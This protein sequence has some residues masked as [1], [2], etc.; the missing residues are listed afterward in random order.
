MMNCM[1]SSNADSMMIV[2]SI[3]WLQRD[4]DAKF[5]CLRN[6]EMKVISII[7]LLTQTLMLK[8]EK[9]KDYLWKEVILKLI[10]HLWNISE[11]KI[12]SQDVF[13][14]KNVQK[15]KTFI[16]LLNKQLQM[17]ENMHFTFKTSSWINVAREEA[18]MK[19]QQFRDDLSLLCKKRKILM[20]IMKRKEVKEIQ[21]RL[22]DQIFQEIASV[23]MT[24]RD[25][26]MSL[27]KLESENIA[28]H[29]MSLKAQAALKKSQTWV[30][31]IAS[32]AHVMHWS[33]A[34][35]THDVHIT[36]NTSNQKMIIKK[37]MKDNAR[38][39]KNLKML[40]IA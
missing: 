6:D 5:K 3:D 20:K 28:L 2:S 38:L 21:K 12:E 11:R 15:L 30:K 35:L 9:N 37:L 31:R 29:M 25:L 10:Q 1:S 32:S 18:I 17:Q 23:S 26:I 36:L 14:V 34:I 22:I 33:F 4:S 39:H 27:R 16:Q 40:K 7:D 19:K 24:Q 13:I 8:K